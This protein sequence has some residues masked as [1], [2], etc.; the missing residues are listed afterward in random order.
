LR[1]RRLIELVLGLPTA[2]I[3]V[4]GETRALLRRALA[5]QVPV[6]ILSRRSKARFTGLFVD[7]VYGASRHRVAALLRKPQA[8]WRRFVRSEV[9]ERALAERDVG[10]GGVCL[11]LAASLELWL[12]R[13]G[14][15]IA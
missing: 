14:V 3:A 13:S 11:W 9:I 15:S 4:R 1:D 7:G 10:R 5:G 2:E 6:A 8:A 12:E